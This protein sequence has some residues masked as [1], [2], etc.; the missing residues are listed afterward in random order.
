MVE[1][2]EKVLAVLQAGNTQLRIVSWNDQEPVLEKRQF[3]K[4]LQGQQKPGRC[5]GFT[6]E[7]LKYVQEH[8]AE[9]Q[10]VMLKAK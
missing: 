10:E 2:R 4:D 7:D 1:V 6:L 9:I 5:K 8:M 3:F